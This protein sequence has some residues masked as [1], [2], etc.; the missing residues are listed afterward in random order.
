MSV[1][2]LRTF[3]DC[4]TYLPQGIGYLRN[5]LTN[6]TEED[7]KWHLAQVFMPITFM[8]NHGEITV[9]QAEQFR[10]L[11]ISLTG[12]QVGFV[13]ENDQWGLKI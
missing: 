2:T 5:Q 13:Q 10:I 3:E 7:Q 11:Y 4:L 9:T 12:H 1:E 8:L 6:E